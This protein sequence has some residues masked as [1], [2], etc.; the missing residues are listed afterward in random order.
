MNLFS[1]ILTI[2]VLSVL[3]LIAGISLEALILYR[4]R[5]SST[6]AEALGRIELVPASVLK[7]MGIGSG[8]TLLL[9]GIYMTSSLSAWSL[10][11]PRL[12]VAMVVLITPVA[13]IFGKQMM[14]LRQSCAA[15]QLS[16]SELHRSLRNPRLK[17]AFFVKTALILGLVLLMTTQ[18]G[19]TGAL[20][21]LAA[22]L[23]LG[24]AWPAFTSRGSQSSRSATA[25]ANQ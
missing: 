15:G 6:A 17:T 4:V 23:V 10:A 2:H 5:R 13:A 25:T 19:L 22:A 3:V 9:T 12:A 7:S 8:L 14:A 20:T 24:I 18:P 16:E 1:T 21:I 11:W